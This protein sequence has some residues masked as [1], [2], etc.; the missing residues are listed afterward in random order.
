MTERRGCR[1][2]LPGIFRV[3]DPQRLL[4]WIGHP[5]DH[6]AW[7][8]VAEARRALETPAPG[9]P[10]ASLAQAREELLIAEGSD[11]FWWYGDDHSSD[12]D[13]EFDELFRR[14]VRNVYRAL[15][16]P[17]P[18]ELF[19]SNIT[20]QPPAVEIQ[21]P[22]GFIHPTI[23]GEVTSY[24]EWVGAGCADVDGSAGAMHEVA[25]R[26]SVLALVEFGFD[27][28]RL[29]L[30]VADA[31]DAGVLAEGAV[32][33]E[34]SEAR[35]WVSARR[36]LRRCHLDWNVDR[37]GHLVAASMAGLSAS[38]VRGELQVS[39]H[40]CLVTTPGGVHRAFNRTAPRLNSPPT[41]SLEFAVAA[42]SVPA[43]RTAWRSPGQPITMHI[44]HRPFIR[45]S[46]RPLSMY[47]NLRMATPG[48][49]TSRIAGLDDFS[50]ASISRPCHF[51]LRKLIRRLKAFV[52]GRNE[53]RKDFGRLAGLAVSFRTCSRVA[54]P[55]VASFSTRASIFAGSDCRTIVSRVDFE[56]MSASRQRLRTSS[57]M[58]FSDS[59]S[60]T[61]VR[62]LPSCGHVLLRVAAL[63]RQ[64]CSIRPLERGQS[65]LWRSPPSRSIT[66]TSSARGHTGVP[67]PTWRQHVAALA[68]DALERPPMR[69]GAA[70]DP[71]LR[72]R[73]QSSVVAHDLARLPGLGRQSMAT[74]RPRRTADAPGLT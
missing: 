41:A 34:L 61:A 19:V 60:V 24:F 57:G 32:E 22:T 17:I 14:H 33:R 65:L 4:I 39:L 2:L 37:G 40:A 47:F 50:S 70:R 5:D 59:D 55:C 8:Q 71:L 18:E 52:I 45:S 49:A 15:D 25:E 6:R 64:L 11:W 30:R 46:K 67:E 28:E 54:L 73:R 69:S 53:N 66:S 63:L 43:D 23:D 20:T 51:P 16:K 7:S 12:H 10:E 9:L 68:S 72:H 1:D 21:P 26:D 58:L 38:S 48:R 3:V 42:G 13:R 62:D 74:R 31:S 36:G 29:F 27:L 56:V 44:H 35:D